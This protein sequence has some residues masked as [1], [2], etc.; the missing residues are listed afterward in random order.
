MI[1]RILTIDPQNGG[2]VIGGAFGGAVTPLMITWGQAMDLALSALIF[3]VV[4][5]I[6][7]FFIARCLTKMT[8]HEKNNN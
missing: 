6:I 7:G 4:G 1:N 8:N 3:S 2:G 5:S